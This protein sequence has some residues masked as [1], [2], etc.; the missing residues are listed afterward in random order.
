MILLHCCVIMCVFQDP[1]EEWDKMQHWMRWCMQ[2]HL[3]NDDDVD[4]DVSS[5]HSRHIATSPRN[6]P[7][8][9][10]SEARARRRLLR[11]N[12]FDTSSSSIDK[13]STSFDKS[14]NRSSYSA[15]PNMRSLR[16]TSGNASRSFDQTT[17]RRVTAAVSRQGRVDFFNSSLPNS[18]DLPPSSTDVLNRQDA[19]VLG[20]CGQSVDLPAIKECMSP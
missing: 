15:T 20:A 10:D 4:L 5:S 3:S 8:R 16:Q 2:H 18:F 17:S 14:P 11:Q 19:L 7:I 1:G 13:F 6:Q 9:A 12:S